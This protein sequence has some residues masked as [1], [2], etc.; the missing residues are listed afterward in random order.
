[1][2]FYDFLYY[3]EILN[4]VHLFSDKNDQATSKLYEFET[5]DRSRIY[6]TECL[7]GLNVIPIHNY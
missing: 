7:Y 6:V 1:M 4:T 5:S 2:I 3:R